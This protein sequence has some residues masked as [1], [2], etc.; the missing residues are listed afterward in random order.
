MNPIS[1]A[2]IQDFYTHLR[3]NNISGA[4]AV[5][6]ML[7]GIAA[8]SS[9]TEKPVVFY[10]AMQSI[11]DTEHPGVL[12]RTMDDIQRRLRKADLERRAAEPENELIAG[13][14]R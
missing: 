4:K 14:I 13:E 1:E 7:I 3:S 9:Q 10:T 12:T 5:L 6:G 11:T 8:A 2:L